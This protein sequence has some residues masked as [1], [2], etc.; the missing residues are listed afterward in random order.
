MWF[1]RSRRLGDDIGT[2]IAY[3]AP[4]VAELSERLPKLLDAGERLRIDTAVARYVA[5][6]VPQD[7]A[8]RVVTFDTL[9]ATL[10]I[11]EVASTAKQ[12]VELVA[13]I[14]FDVAN[15]LAMPWLREKIA[16][17]P[18]DQH[19]RMLAKSAMLDDL[20]GLQRSITASVLAGAPTGGT[21]SA[22]VARWQQSGGRALERA[23]QLLG[24]LRAVP[25][26][27][28]AMLSVTLRELR[29]LG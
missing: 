6:G 23:A 14:Y 16:A 22:L 10:D 18:G 4:G 1:L 19:W 3:F 24:E 13:A 29:A 5:Q 21:S 12:P 20:A 15:R 2:T 17:L 28:S 11:A 26:P 8:V 7:L 27:D 25:S 9:H